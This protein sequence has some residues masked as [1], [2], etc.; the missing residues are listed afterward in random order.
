MTKRLR[1]PRN[2]DPRALLDHVFQHIVRCKKSSVGGFEN[3]MNSIGMN[4]DRTRQSNFTDTNPDQQGN[5]SN[6]VLSND[7]YAFGANMKLGH[8]TQSN[9]NNNNTI[10]NKSNNDND[11]GGM[12]SSEKDST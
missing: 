10:N 4:M 12:T 5:R 3:S 7:A 9:N 11:E 1:S 6:S 2:R 8:A